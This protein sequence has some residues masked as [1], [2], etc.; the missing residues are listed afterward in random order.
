MMKKRFDFNKNGVN[1]P[2]CNLQKNSARAKLSKPAVTDP[3]RQVRSQMP[4]DQPL[5]AFS[6]LI[7][8]DDKAAC[9]VMV[10]MVTLKYPGGTIHRADNGVQ[11]I[12]LFKEH[13]PDIVLT[14]V[15]MPVMDG[16][17]LLRA[18]RAIR[19]DASCI[20]LTAYSDKIVF[21]KFKDLGVSAYLLKPLDFKELFAALE[22][23]ITEISS[24]SGTP[25]K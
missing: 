15:N 1:F 23:C 10:R 2:W 7:V 4:K 9:D 11:G 24:R 17:E 21:Q 3:I 22:K 8:E 20:V 14:D 19:A 25:V 18:I 5:P 13:I 6:L 16:I 12:E